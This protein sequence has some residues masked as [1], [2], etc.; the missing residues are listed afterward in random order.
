MGI[1]A[2]RIDADTVTFGLPLRAATA[3]GA[4]DAATTNT[5][6]TWILAGTTVSGIR[7]EVAA[8]VDSAAV[9]HTDGA[10]CTLADSAP[11]L[12]GNETALADLAA[13]PTVVQIGLEI[14]ADSGAVGLPR[15]TG[16]DVALRSQC[17][18]GAAAGESHRCQKSDRPPA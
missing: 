9:L 1:V 16:G 6:S 5:T 4:A 8:T 18:S 3:T 13:C 17:P 7:G 12:D 15:L 14:D 2:A 11:A 10:G